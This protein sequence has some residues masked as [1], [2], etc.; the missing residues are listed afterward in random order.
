MVGIISVGEALVSHLGIRDLIHFGVVLRL[1]GTP[2]VGIRFTHLG[3]GILGM[4]V[5][6]GTLSECI[7]QVGT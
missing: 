6:V 4:Q 2:G 1:D 5:L 3:D 7:T